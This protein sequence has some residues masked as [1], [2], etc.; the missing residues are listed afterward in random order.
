MK[1]YLLELKRAAGLTALVVT[2]LSTGMQAALLKAFALEDALTLLTVF[3]RTAP[4]TIAVALIAALVMEAVDSVEDRWF[5]TVV[6]AAIVLWVSTLLGNWLGGLRI[7]PVDVLTGGE[8]SVNPFVRA[9]FYLVN[10]LAGYFKAYGGA[11]F[12]SSVALGCFLFW[13]G[14]RYVEIKRA[15]DAPEE[16]PSAA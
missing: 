13:A 3:F 11:T 16:P 4:L 6:K 8:K 10:A 14:R 9:A 5:W 7:E 15:P 2:L 12:L 1:Q